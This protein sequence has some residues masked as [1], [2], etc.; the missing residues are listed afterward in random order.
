MALSVDPPHTVFSLLVAAAFY[1]PEESLRREMHDL[2]TAWLERLD[3]PP[4]A[5][6]VRRVILAEKGTTIEP[7]VLSEADVESS[8]FL[9]RAAFSRTFSRTRVRIV[10]R[11]TIGLDG[12]LVLTSRL[13]SYYVT[14]YPH[15]QPRRQPKQAWTFVPSMIPPP[16]AAGAGFGPAS[17]RSGTKGFTITVPLPDCQVDPA[18]FAR[19]L[20]Q[21]SR[22][23]GVADSFDR[24]GLRVECRKGEIHILS[25]SPESMIRCLAH[26]TARATLVL[27]GGEDPM[28]EADIPGILIRLDVPSSQR[29]PLRTVIGTTP[30]YLSWLSGPPVIPFELE[31]RQKRGLTRWLRVP[32][33]WFQ[34]LEETAP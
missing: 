34:A 24:L 1:H 12:G 33:D 10:S 31:L 30:A 8:V 4:S 11:D 25:G 26:M 27:S 17:L 23:D 21:H 14:R 29:V 6:A 3:G 28:G 16:D 13:A 2:L 18:S 9:A 19:R 32:A 22:I 20:Q 5:D 15:G 7:F